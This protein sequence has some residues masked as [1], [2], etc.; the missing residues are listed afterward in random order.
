MLSALYL[1]GSPDEGPNAAVGTI[2]AKVIKTLLGK[3]YPSSLMHKLAF[4]AY[5]ASVPQSE[6]DLDWLSKDSANVQAYIADPLCGFKFTTQGYIDLA[7]GLREV[8][9]ESEWPV[10]NPDLPIRFES[11][12]NDP[13][14][15]PHGLER[16]V[17]RLK[18]IGFQNVSFAYIPE[19]RHE[20][21]NDIRKKELTKSLVSWLNQAMK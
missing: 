16:S 2:L 9:H 14:Y 4:S 5:S 8:Y 6:T 11:G 15:K 7:E 20:I 19:C 1:S 21:Y 10:Y 12:V 13:S 17:Q 18:D 3:R